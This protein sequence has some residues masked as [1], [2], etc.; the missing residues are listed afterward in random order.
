[1]SSFLASSYLSQDLVNQH[2]Q[3]KAD[4]PALSADRS[5]PADGAAADM[6][7]TD[8]D[9]GMAQELAAAYPEEQRAQIESGF[10]QMQ[11]VYNQL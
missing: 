10:M 9:A 4:S 7:M 2:H 6:L 8:G 5:E 3:P 11:E 1:M